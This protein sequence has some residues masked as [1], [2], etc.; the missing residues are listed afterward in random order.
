MDDK[1]NKMKIKFTKYG[2]QEL[3]KL[4]EKFDYFK[5]HV[6]NNELNEFEH[7]VNNSRFLI[8]YDFE[9]ISIGDLCAKIEKEKFDDAV[10]VD[11][12]L[13]ESLCKKVIEI[14]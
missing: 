4:D 3:D 13:T 2:K 9:F 11:K 14:V 10:E 7:L 6:Y 5:R 12:I 8:E 1:L